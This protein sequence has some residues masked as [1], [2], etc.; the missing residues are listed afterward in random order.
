MARLTDLVSES[1]ETVE[2]EEEVSMELESAII[3]NLLD[4]VD[5]IIEEGLEEDE[6]VELAE[7]LSEMDEDDS[8][9][10]LDEAPKKRLKRMCGDGKKRVNGACVK[11][12]RKELLAKKLYRKR[13]KKKIARAAKKYQMKFGKILAKRAK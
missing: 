7:A 2:T 5:T 8:E 10:S 13:N 1:T 9:E 6:L 3:E 11:T 4:L 12:S